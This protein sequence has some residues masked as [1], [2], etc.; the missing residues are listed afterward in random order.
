VGLLTTG[1]RALP[2][3]V[4]F[5]WKT[6]SKPFVE[7]RALP[8]VATLVLPSV[9]LA[10]TLVLHGNRELIHATPLLEEAFEEFFSS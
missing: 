5:F 6:P 10:V 3:V 8:L 7:L 2:L 4:T 9:P 1:L